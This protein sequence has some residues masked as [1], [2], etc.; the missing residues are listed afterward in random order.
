MSAQ[1]VRLVVRPQPDVMRL[2]EGLYDF[3]RSHRQTTD[4][5]PQPVPLRRIS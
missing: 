2:I 4:P 3:A 5:V 1:F